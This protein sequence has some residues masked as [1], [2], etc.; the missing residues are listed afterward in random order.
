M[1]LQ[2]LPY[3]VEHHN[4]LPEL[5]VAKE[6]FDSAKVLD[7][8]CTKIGQVFVK[9]HVQNILGVT[10]LHNH[11]FLNPYEI[12]VN[13]DSVAVPWATT[14]GTTELSAVN[15]TAWRF[16]DQGLAPYE[17]AYKAVVAPLDRHPMQ[18]FLLELAAILNKYNLT[19]ILGICSLGETSVDGPATIEF[20][21]GRANITLPFDIAPNDGGAIDA[22]WQFSSNQLSPSAEAVSACQ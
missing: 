18:G 17:F 20:T 9:H 6:Q 16:T 19:N 14:S 12:L 11:F 3:S 2:V 8:L 5:G 21:E 1:A 7:I 15:P 4:S 10:L 22:M 13:I